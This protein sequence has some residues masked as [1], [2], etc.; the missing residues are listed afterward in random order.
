[1]NKFHSSPVH[2]RKRGLVLG[3]TIRLN[4]KSFKLKRKSSLFMNISRSEGYMHQNGCSSIMQGGL[5][6]GELYRECIFLW[7]SKIDAGQNGVRASQGLL[8][9]KVRSTAVSQPLHVYP[10]GPSWLLRFGNWGTREVSEFLPNDRP[11]WAEN[12]INCQHFG[13]LYWTQNHKSK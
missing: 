1:M 9:T 2:W 7:G 6:L 3:E 12:K 5:N 11:W 4:R 13:I 8:W 10:Q